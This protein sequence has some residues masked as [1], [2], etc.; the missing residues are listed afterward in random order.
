[1]V[2]QGISNGRAQHML[3]SEREAHIIQRAI[4]CFATHGFSVSTREL[5]KH[6]GV[7]QPLIYRYF[8]SKEALAERVHQEV[9]F[10]R[11]NPE[12]ERCLSDTQRPLEERLVEYLLDY[13]N[14]I[15]KNDWVRLFIFAALNDPTLN[16]RYIQLL[17]EK[18]FLPV[19]RELRK[20]Y[21]VNPEPSE[22]DIELIW[23]FHS[24]FFYM[25]IRRWVYR[26]TVPEDIQRVIRQRVKHFL[27]GYHALLQEEAAH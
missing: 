17:R 23:G 25:G 24:S 20:S 7:T 19:L 15:L 6:I 3:A 8:G 21:D 13:T 10:S 14:A 5:A 18:I 26:M 4:E 22:L 12:W 16:Q 2:N 1:M 9:F 11:W 27:Y